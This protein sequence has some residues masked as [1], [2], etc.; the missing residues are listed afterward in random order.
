MS[1]S[2]GR[3]ISRAMGVS[4]AARARPMDEKISTIAAHTATNAKSTS[5]DARGF[6]SGTSARATSCDATTSIKIL[7]VSQRDSSV[8]G[9]PR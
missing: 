6:A 3:V 2:T 7:N 1:H 5:A 4:L 9:S 8:C